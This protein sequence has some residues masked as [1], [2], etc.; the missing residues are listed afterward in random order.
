MNKYAVSPQ[1]LP[2]DPPDR[3]CGAA[4][5]AWSTAASVVNNCRNICFHG[6]KE[7]QRR[8]YSIGVTEQTPTVAKSNDGFFLPDN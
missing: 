8:L 4:P 7:E 3:V 5:P 6:L 2:G 1:G